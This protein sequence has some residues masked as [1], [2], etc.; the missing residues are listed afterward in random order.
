M[1]IGALLLGFSFFL[2]KVLGIIRDHLLA[3]QF[4]AGNGEGVSA[5]FNLDTYYAAFRMP[6]FLFHQLSYGV[7]AAAFVPIF[8]EIL[9]KENRENAFRFASDVMRLVSL[10]MVGFSIIIFIIAPYIIPV[11]V[12]GFSKEALDVTI[13][14]TRIMLVTP[15]FFT[16]GSI[17]GGMQNAL[18]KFLALSLAPVFYNIGIIGG[19]VFLSKTYGVYG[20][21]IGVAI[22]AFLNMLV[23]L[24]SILKFGFRFSPSPKWWTA[25]VREMVLL[26]LPRILGMS[27]TQVSLIVDTII[28][29]TL[30]AGSITIINFAANLESLPIGIVGVSVAI[31]SFGVLSSHAADQN[32]IEFKKEISTNLRKI[33]FLL[34][35][36]A[37][38]MFSLRFQIVKIVFEKGAF[39]GTDTLTTANTLGFFLIGLIFGGIMFLLARGFYALKNTKTPVKASI[40]AVA[41]NIIASIL[42]TKVLKLET[43]GLAIAN[44]I[45]DAFNAILLLVLLSKLLK[46]SVIDLGETAKFFAAAIL[47]FAVVNFTKN[48][49]ENV[50]FQ[51]AVSAGVGALVYFFACFAMKCKVFKRYYLKNIYP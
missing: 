16:I 9:R 31:V 13:L 41:I 38:G 45:A 2:S 8:V 26:S 24:P 17:A 4:G 14:S 51:T 42:L 39:T 25:R 6:D 1:K 49:F 40:A 10:I 35:P 34:I 50:Y 3:R 22:G 29:S 7:L 28:A 43:Y 47:M 27:A 37:F 33:L 46:E 18:H 11:F 30:A 20:V 44:S 21:A 48:Y 5:V 12:P 32:M 19:I 36:L 15:I 23:Q